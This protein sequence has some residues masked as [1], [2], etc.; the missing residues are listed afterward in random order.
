MPLRRVGQLPP[1]V[2]L[3]LQIRAARERAEFTQLLRDL[4]IAEDFSQPHLVSHNAA[5]RA[6]A[7]RRNLGDYT[8]RRLAGGGAGRLFDRLNCFS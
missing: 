7:S 4:D 5:S 2:V 6:K 8:I 3:I 1:A